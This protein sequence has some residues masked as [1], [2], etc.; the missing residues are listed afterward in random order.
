MLQNPQRKA[1]KVWEPFKIFAIN[2]LFMQGRMLWKELLAVLSF[3]NIY[4]YLNIAI[5][6]TTVREW[7]GKKIG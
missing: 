7:D 1:S 2:S 4:C 3:E 6:Y 5:S